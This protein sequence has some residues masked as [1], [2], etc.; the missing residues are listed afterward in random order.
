MLDAGFAHDRTTGKEDWLTPPF[1]IDQLG[2]FDTDPCSPLPRPWDTAKTHYT[3]ATN[4]LNQP[5]HGRVWLNPPYGNETWK[6]MSR[7]AQ[8]GNGIALIFARTETATFF[9]WVWNHATAILFIRGRLNFYTKEGRRGGVAGAP[10]CLI[11]YGEENA[12][13]LKCA[14]LRDGGIEGRFLMLGN[15]AHR[16]AAE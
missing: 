3:I 4:G 9:P 1:I 10:S 16:P 15:E 13:R 14:T 11:A 2:P 12:L 7:L 6:W 5:W 8:H